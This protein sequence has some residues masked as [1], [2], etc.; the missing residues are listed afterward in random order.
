MLREGFDYPP[1]SIAGIVTG[2]DLKLSLN[3][4]LAGSS[5]SW[6]MGAQENAEAPKEISSHTD[7]STKEDS[8]TATKR[9]TSLKKK[10][11]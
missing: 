2:F 7:A 3:S 5:V 8:L 4:L 6:G 9:H 11:S 10:M 1:F